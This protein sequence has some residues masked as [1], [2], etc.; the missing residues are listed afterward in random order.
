MDGILLALAG[1]S[2]LDQVQSQYGEGFNRD[3]AAWAEEPQLR[4]AFGKAAKASDWFKRQSRAQAWVAAI[5]GCFDDAT[6]RD[7][8]LLRQMNGMRGWIDRA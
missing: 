8:D 6:I 2:S 7:S 4:T 3:Y 5:A 1:E